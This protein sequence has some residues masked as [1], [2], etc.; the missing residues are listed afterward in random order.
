M[1]FLEPGWGTGQ[2]YVP[3]EGGR[4]CASSRRAWILDV[5]HWGC[6]NPCQ[7][8]ARH[9]LAL[10]PAHGGFLRGG[11][12]PVAARQMERRGIYLL[13]ASWEHPQTLP[14]ASSS[15]WEGKALK[16]GGIC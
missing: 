9:E 5:G 10:C 2:I 4:G 7:P 8:H 13:R 12:G 6:P 1:L 3:A 14:S 11:G 16:S 15:S